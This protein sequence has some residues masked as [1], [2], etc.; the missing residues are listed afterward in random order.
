MQ[1]LLAEDAVFRDPTAEIF[2]HGMGAGPVQ[3]AAAIADWFRRARAQAE[4]FELTIED[5]FYSLHHA[6][7]ITRGTADL[8]GQVTGHFASPL[9]VAL[10]IRDGK[11]VR[12]DDYWQAERFLQRLR[13][14]SEASATEGAQDPADSGQQE[15]L[16]KHRAGMAKILFLQGRWKGQSQP[17]RQEAWGQASGFEG[18][19]EPAMKD[20]YLQ[21][22]IEGAGYRWLISYDW[23]Q[24]RYRMSSIDEVSGLLDIYEGGFDAGGRLV[25]SNLESGTHYLQGGTKIHNRLTLA[26]V[27]SG[28]HFGVEATADLGQ[29]WFHQVR[30][31][32][33][34]EL[35]PAE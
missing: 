12:H 31:A 8:T 22:A 27:G 7:F 15:M 16:E 1:A 18:Y 14:H 13:E 20:K 2:G 3:G 19:F 17:F 10:E 25:L 26:A 34:T 9:I 11:V 5:A 4:N 6:V 21:G 32:F 23:V 33:G 24:D 28:F 29:T 35:P 30:M